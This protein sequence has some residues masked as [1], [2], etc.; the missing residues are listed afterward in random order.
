VIVLT[1]VVTTST[2]DQLLDVPEIVVVEVPLARA[3]DSKAVDVVSLPPLL[4][5]ADEV[6]PAVVLP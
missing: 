6:T 2:P 1:N 3:L 5:V 4:L